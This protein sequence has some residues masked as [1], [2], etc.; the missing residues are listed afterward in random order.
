MDVSG[1]GLVAI[2]FPAH[3]TVRFLS[4]DLPL[5]EAFAELLCNLRAHGVISSDAD[6]EIPHS[7]HGDELLIK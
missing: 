1:P 7:A 4:C 6:V 5:R 3:K 2:D